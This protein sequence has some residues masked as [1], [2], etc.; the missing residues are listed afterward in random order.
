MHFEVLPNTI[1]Y[2][3]HG[4][5][6][7]GTN[8]PTSDHD[9]KGVAVAPREH[10]IGFAYTFEQ[11]IVGESVIFD[12]RKFMNLA[13]ACNP[14]IIEILFADDSDQL[15]VSPV[16]ERLLEVREQFLS[17]KARHTFAGYA[18]AQ[19][20]RIKT[21][22]RWLLNPPKK[23]PE[24]A[25]YNLLEQRKID[26]SMLGA[27]EK[28]IEEGH[29]LAPNALELVDAEKRYQAALKEWQQ[30]EKWKE[31]R[32][33]ARAELEAKYGYDTKHAMHLVRLMCMC[34]EILRGEGVRVRRLDAKELLE[35]RHGAWTYDELME[36][37]ETAEAHLGSLY[38]KSTLR[39]SP[40]LHFLNNVCVELHELHWRLSAP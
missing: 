11:Q 25:E 12:L 18:Y 13:A 15:A 8:L 10:V 16:G 30:Y 29:T 26:A 5:R 22:R 2:V 1:L 37:A 33:E 21:H 32:N 40:D 3:R 6:A 36:F 28:L 27:A 35:I 31:E 24:R 14:N 19:L 38:E 20:K 17:K 34:D 23:K 9:F 7:Y 39:H 4:S